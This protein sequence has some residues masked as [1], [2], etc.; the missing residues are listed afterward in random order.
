MLFCFMLCFVLFM[1]CIFLFHRFSGHWLTWNG[2]VVILTSK[3]SLGPNFHK[4]LPCCMECRR[5]ETRSSDEK[6]VCLSIRPFVR[7]S[8]CLSVCQT[9]GLWQNRS[10][11]YPD[12]IPYE[13]SFSLV[14]WE[15]EWLVTDDPINL[16]F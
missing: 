11:I 4:L 12:S 6:A 3:F 14:F 9:H 16:K 1:F 7:L 10:K 2:S 15:E 13:R 8:V 5:G